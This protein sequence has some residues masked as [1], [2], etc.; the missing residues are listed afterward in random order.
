MTV[1]MDLDHLAKAV[2]VRFPT[3]NFFFSSSSFPFLNECTI[4]SPH[5]RNGEL[6]SPSTVQ[7]TYKHIFKFFC[8]D[9]SLLL[10]LLIYSVIYMGMDIGILTY[11]SDHNPALLYL[12]YCSNC[13][14]FGYWEI[15]TLALVFLRQTLSPW[16]LERRGALPYFL[17]LLNTLD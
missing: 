2:F 8:T 6:H 14:S 4:C 13:F 1:D 16:G 10:H 12:F 7:S 15:F 5:P 17:M 11:S 9:V 3:A